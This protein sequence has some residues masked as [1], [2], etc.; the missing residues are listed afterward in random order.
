MRRKLYSHAKNMSK[1][2]RWICW[3]VR[4]IHNEYIRSADITP[5]WHD[6]RIAYMNELGV[7]GFGNNKRHESNVK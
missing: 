1:R 2:V 5:N 4:S 6:M 7:I 3:E